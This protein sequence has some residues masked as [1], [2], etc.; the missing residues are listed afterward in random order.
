MLDASTVSKGEAIDT[1]SQV[2]VKP[3]KKRSRRARARKRSRATQGAT[4]VRKKRVER[5]FPRVPLQEAIKVP[6]IIRH[7][8]GGN[9]WPPDEVR[10]AVEYPK[11]DSFYYLTAAARDFGL[12]EGTRETPEISLADLGRR[13]A[14]AETPEEERSTRREAF[15]KIELFR[16]VLDYYKGSNLPEMQYLK[17]TLEAKFGL[18]PSIHEEFANL[19]RQ[20]CEYLGITEGGS[21][22]D[23]KRRDAGKRDA[24]HVA[25]GDIVTVAEPETDTGLLCFVA[26][27][28]TERASEHPPGFFNEVLRQLIAPAGR[29]AGF[30]VVIARKQ[31]S[32][33]IHATIVNGLLDADL[34]VADLT[35]HNPNVLCE[36]GMRLAEDRPVALVRAT[37]TKPIFDVDHL[38]RVEEYNPCLWP[39]T[40]ESDL[41]RIVEHIKAT[42]GNRDGGKSYMK[43]LRTKSVS[44]T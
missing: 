15:E 33:V 38:L 1:H 19:F 27:P 10:S 39:S 35:E 18:D 43:I 24:V 12:T 44:P 11:G 40:V 31:G 4:R 25:G 9:P 42:W 6:L 7:K 29:L 23:D 36:L 17:N 28:F 3:G 21:D 16:Q 2:V 5:P 14:Y 37:G 26:M 13:L 8:N 20:N 34:V 32:D 30:R 22:S 41:P